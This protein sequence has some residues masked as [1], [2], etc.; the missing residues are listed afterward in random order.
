MALARES[1]DPVHVD[2]CDIAL[3]RPPP[4]WATA[5]SVPSDRMLKKRALGQRRTSQRR[6]TQNDGE[7]E[8]IENE[9]EVKHK[10]GQRFS[11]DKFAQD[12]SPLS[13]IACGNGPD[14]DAEQR[15][16][17]RRRKRLQISA[18]VIAMTAI[19]IMVMQDISYMGAIQYLMGVTNLFNQAL[20]DNKSIEGNK[21]EQ[22][23]NYH[24]RLLSLR[25]D[26]NSEH[27]KR[28]KPDIK[29]LFLTV[30]K[31]DQMMMIN[32]NFYVLKCER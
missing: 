30:R 1:A 7:G 6:Q 18:L 9:V 4:A 21:G 19:G 23:V 10:R 2:V 5:N 11:Q 12:M 22:C 8:T 17:Y 13:V 26:I 28:E 24:N 25:K 16:S 15:R 3:L 20:L 29:L 14:G 31:R 32:T 27:E